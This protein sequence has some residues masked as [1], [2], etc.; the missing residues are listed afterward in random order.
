MCTRLYLDWND[1]ELTAL[2]GAAKNTVLLERFRMKMA[3]RFQDSGEAEPK[4]LLTAVAP[5]K[6]GTRN[7]YV[8]RWGFNIGEE[9][10]ERY[11]APVENIEKD[12][13]FRDDWKS[14]RCMIPVTYFI[15]RQHLKANDGTVT[16]GKEYVV[17]PVG[18]AHTYIC[19]IYRI[20]DHLP[21]FILLT[22]PSQGEYRARMSDRIP[23]IL[24]DHLIDHWINPST[25]PKDLL[26]YAISDFIF[27]DY[28]LPKE[29]P[30]YY[31]SF[32]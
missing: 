17:Q 19:G 7:L 30:D 22:H 11:T 25:Q 27:E 31:T 28:D 29:R 9:L 32:G 20:E 16:L 5:D 24:P 23:L 15:E 3:V 18:L 2:T 14:H 4:H 10:R 13:R 1:K 12:Q 6:N 21:C 26:R 8:M